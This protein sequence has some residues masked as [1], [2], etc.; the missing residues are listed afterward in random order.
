VASRVAGDHG[1]DAGDP[2]ERGLLAPEAAA[3]EDRGRALGRG[4]ER[5]RAGDDKESESDRKT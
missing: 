4:G 3:R 1:D 5:E 2:F